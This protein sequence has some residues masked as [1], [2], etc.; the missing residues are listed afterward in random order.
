LWILPLNKKIEVKIL[1]GKEIEHELAQDLW[2]DSEN[3]RMIAYEPNR[4]SRVKLNNFKVEA[5]EGC[6]SVSFDVDTGALT[7][8]EIQKI[9]VH[10]LPNNYYT[11]AISDLLPASGLTAADKLTQHSAK[12]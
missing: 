6:S 4:Y 3:R 9:R 12:T 1:K 10:V 2:F 11:S 5:K 8:D 7:E